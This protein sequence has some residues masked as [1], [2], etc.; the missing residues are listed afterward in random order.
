MNKFWTPI[1]DQKTG[2]Y[3]YNRETK[4]TAWKV[5][6]ASRR[7]RSGSSNGNSDIAKNNNRLKD[8]RSRRDGDGKAKTS[9][10]GKNNSVGHDSEWGTAVDPATRQTYY[11]H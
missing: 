6:N 8:S 9:M 11:F 3:F 5:P 1:V 10:D 7:S 4:E 2:Q